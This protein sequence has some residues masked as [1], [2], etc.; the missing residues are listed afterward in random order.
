MLDVIV[1]FVGCVSFILF[2]VM[3]IADVLWWILDAEW[4]DSLLDF[5]PFVVMILITVGL[6]LLTK[7]CLE[8]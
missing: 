6:Y 3:V 2:V 8:M 4:C 1:I 5:L 7:L